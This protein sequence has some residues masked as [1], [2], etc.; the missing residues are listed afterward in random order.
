M[1]VIKHIAVTAA[2][3]FI[4]LGIPFIYCTGGR[5]GVDAV[6]SATVEVTAPSGNF[7]VVI[8]PERSSYD[9]EWERF[10]NG[11]DG[12]S[13]M[14]D[15]VCL[16]VSSDAAGNELARSYMSRLPENQMKIHSEESLMA[17]SME[18]HG[19]FDIMIISAETADSLGLDT[20]TN[21]TV[22]V[23]KEE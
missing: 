19:L 4:A 3:L 20:G 9:T 14:E 5:I 10:F 8:N 15:I 7:I 12:G 2:S 11:G 17:V 13:I 23:R 1:K 22:T 16:T 18:E 21:I 6:S